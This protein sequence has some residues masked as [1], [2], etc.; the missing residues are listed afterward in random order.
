MV[1]DGRDFSTDEVGSVSEFA[2]VDL[3][4]LFLSCD[5]CKSSL[6]C[7]C[8]YCSLANAGRL[9][10][11]ECGSHEKLSESVVPKT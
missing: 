7:P 11:K 2:N 5:S 4:L 1:L 8:V 6:F 10:V 3:D 9:L